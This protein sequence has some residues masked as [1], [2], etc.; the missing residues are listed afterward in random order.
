[1]LWLEYAWPP[2]DNPPGIGRLSIE[3][4][5]DSDTHLDS[6]REPNIPNISGVYMKFY[7]ETPKSD[8]EIHVETNVVELRKSSIPGAGIGVFAKVD[9]SGG[10]NL[11]FYRGEWL[12]EK[13][14]ENGSSGI[15]TLALENG[16]HI[17]AENHGYNWV[18]RLNSPKGTNKKS[19]LY[20]DKDG[21]TFT[22]RNIKAG[23]ELLIGYGSSYWNCTRRE[24]TSKRS[25]VSNKKIPGITRKRR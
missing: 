17:D 2:S 15:Y 7:P 19:N 16:I 10:D 13:E 5:N 11:G 1:M 24:K 21:Q 22:S 23:E 25:K 9:I 18:S 3:R 20:W 6:L 4:N 12:T 14:F 8:K